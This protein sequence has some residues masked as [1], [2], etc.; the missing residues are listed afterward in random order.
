[1]LAKRLVKNPVTIEFVRG[2]QITSISIKIEGVEL[3]NYRG[4][5]I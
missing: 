3:R 2:L 1:M 4:F 5:K